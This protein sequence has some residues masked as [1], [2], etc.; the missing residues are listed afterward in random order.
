[1]RNFRGQRSR[2]RANCKPFCRLHHSLHGR[3]PAVR[4]LQGIISFPAERLRFQLFVR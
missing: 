3:R 4:H 2:R 1:M